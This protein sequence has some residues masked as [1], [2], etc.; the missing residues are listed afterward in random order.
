MFT[1]TNNRSGAYLRH[2]RPTTEETKESNGNTQCVSFI[3]WQSW[4]L[5]YAL[6][7]EVHNSEHLEVKVKRADVNSFP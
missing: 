6:F 5:S 2:K 7:L 4:N 1:T 3:R